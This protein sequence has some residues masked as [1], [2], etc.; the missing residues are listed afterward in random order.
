MLEK[1]N[2]RFKQEEEKKSGTLRKDSL[3]NIL[4]SGKKKELKNKQL[5]RDSIKYAVIYIIKIPEGE[6]TE[7]GKKYL[8]KK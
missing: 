8:K 7:R 4:L 2:S 3:S 6:E 1:F 5:L